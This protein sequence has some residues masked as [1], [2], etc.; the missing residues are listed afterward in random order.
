MWIPY[1]E[2]YEV[3]VEG[4]VR[5]RKTG[6]VLKPWLSGQNRYYAVEIYGKTTNVHRLV[7]LCFLP[8]IQ[9]PKDQVDHLNRDR[10]DNRASNLQW[11]SASANQRN[12]GK[13]NITIF[14]RSLGCIY[15]R[16]SFKKH[17]EYIYRKQFKT[18]EEAT[19]ARDA[20]KSS[21]EYRLSM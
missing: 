15:Y 5:N 16:V 11:K 1:D 3:S 20:F 10:S 19:A 6:L 18:L 21:E 7:A 14:R 13:Q 2:L 9:R 4:Q 12:H 17:G 8:R